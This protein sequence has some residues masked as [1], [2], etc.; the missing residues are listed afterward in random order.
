M[1]LISSQLAFY[2]GDKSVRQN[3]RA[4]LRYVAFLC[5]VIVVYAVLFHVIMTGVE[6]QEHS[7]VTGFYWTLTVMS[8]LGFGDITF[9]SDIGRLFSILV[10]ISG[11]VLL[12]I[13]LP[14]AFIRYFYAPWLEAQIQT[15]AP[16]EVPEGT[17]GHIIICTYDT[18][19]EDLV[20]RFENQG[21]SYFVLEPDPLRAAELRNDGVAVIAGEPDSADTHRALRT[22]RA[23]L[24]FANL[25]DTVNTNVTLTVR[26]VA[27]EVPLVT[28]ASAPE[29][30][31]VLELSGATRVLP[32]KRWL[33]EHLANRVNAVNAQSHEVGRYEDLIIAE[34]P[35]RNTPLVGRTI[36]DTRL[37]EIAGVSIIAVWERGRLHPVGP[38]FR[39]T[40]TSVPV[41]VGT[42][43]QLEEL[44]ELLFIYDFNPNPVVLIG[45]GRVGRAAVTALLLKDT[46]VN[47]VEK[48]P[49]FCAR[50]RDLGAT[51]FEGDAAD[52]D[53]LMKAG[54][55]DAPSVL[56]TTHDDAM[57]I[58]LAS[59]C[60]R[61]NPDLR[62]VS[63]ITLERNIESIHRAGADFVLSY[64]SLGVAA[65]ISALQGKD[66][67]V[68]GEDLDLF[69]LP[70]P[71]SL[72]GETLLTS[73]IGAGTGLI[74]IGIQ[75]NGEVITN[76]SPDT[77][78]EE[79][80]E[81]VMMGSTA[82]RIKFWDLFG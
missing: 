43:S 23:A 80:S 71:R 51:A 81:L 60:R 57:N 22:D 9:T 68:L 5:A 65:V 16:R 14:F 7:W 1:K 30:V 70:A 31:D 28:I 67:V 77:K 35:V 37:R 4:L 18:I 66:L 27:P 26:E 76:P 79:G 39:L 20:E 82:Q 40:E 73:G 32:L 45:A 53:L 47:V 56:L 36:R 61:L 15:R 44:D 10:L 48:R 75:E 59:Y 63:R 78:L 42:E 33:G 21:R 13:V 41:V 11:V 49:E 62:I 12:L 50:A 74:V 52:Y 64:A 58:Y 69:A 6:G 3:M 34:I 19:A 24:V 72:Q 8:T 54:L 46:P 2:F 29:S 38:D 25:E 55:Q 17:T